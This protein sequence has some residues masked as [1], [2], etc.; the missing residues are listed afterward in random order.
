M[1]PLNKGPLL[2]AED[3]IQAVDALIDLGYKREEVI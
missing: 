3:Y 2:T 1:H